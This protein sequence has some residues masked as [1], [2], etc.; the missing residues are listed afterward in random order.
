M[1][2]TDIPCNLDFFSYDVA[3]GSEIL[4]CIKIDK[5]LCDKA[6]KCSAS[7]AFYLFSPTCLINSIIHE[8]THVRSSIY[9]K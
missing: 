3:S 9:N 7:L 1:G 6:I 8:Y 4:P 2:I 5:T